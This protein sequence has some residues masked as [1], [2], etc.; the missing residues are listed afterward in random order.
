[1]NKNGKNKEEMQDLPNKE[2]RKGHNLPLFFSYSKLSFFL[3]K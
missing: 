2:Q 3:V 1:M